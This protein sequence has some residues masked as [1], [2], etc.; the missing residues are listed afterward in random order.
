MKS[1]TLIFI[2]LILVVILGVNYYLENKNG[3]RTLLADLV[4]AD[5]SAITAFSIYPNE[6]DKQ[7]VRFVRGNDDWK[8][9][10]D[11]KSVNADKSTIFAM[12]R[13]L[14][15]LKPTRLASTSKDKWEKY[16]VTDSLGLSAKIEVDGDVVADLV[17]GKFDYN[18]Q[19]QSA[20][21][22]VRLADQDEVYAVKAYL[23]MTFNRE[24]EAFRNRSLIMADQFK[25]TRVTYTY[26]GDSSFVL[27]KDGNGY[28]MAD[29]MAVDSL[30]CANYLASMS[31]LGGHTYVDEFDP[32]VATPSHTITFE[33]ENV[34]TITLNAYPWD[35]PHYQ[36]LVSSK[37]PST[38]ISGNNDL[39]N[40]TFVPRS[41]LMMQQ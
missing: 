25:W 1:K 4:E 6:F 30:A 3:D 5:T 11:G 16:E 39:F 15:D 22:Y 41:K 33:G 8:V 38:Y 2:L 37:N 14:Q 31:R 9:Q 10:Y 32:A 19:K 7:E 26:P 17:F 21:S 20:A 29:G 40:R 34:E 12:L 18:Q 27:T 36:V 23:S 35:H 24:P 13:D 28:W